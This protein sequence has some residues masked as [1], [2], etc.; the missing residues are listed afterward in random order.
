[1]IEVV[2][3]QRDNPNTVQFLDQDGSIDFSS[4]TR[5]LLKFKG[6]LIVADTDVDATLID[7]SAGDGDVTFR[8]ND[9]SVDA[10]EYPSSLIVY[11]TGHPD[12]QILVHA[13]EN[14]LFF[15]FIDPI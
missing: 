14:V 15:K 5:M 10:G 13:D 2:Y 6:S 8:L 4:A 9:L 12:G 3:N 7:Y 1:M 11:D